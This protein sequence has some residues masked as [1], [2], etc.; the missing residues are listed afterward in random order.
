M[1]PRW[2]RTTR[3]ET[4]VVD[5]TA[6]LSLMVV[7]IPFLLITAVFSRMTILE[8]QAPSGKVGNSALSDPL[9]L[10][11][12]VREHTIEVHYRGQK[13]DTR[14]ART[15]DEQALVSLGEVVDE[16]KARFPQSLEATILLEPQISYEYLVH[17]MDVV[18]MQQ[19]WQDEALRKLERFPLIALGEIAPLP[20]RPDRGA[21]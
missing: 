7:L 8:L 6:F 21:R 18:R 20:R 5:V 14:I 3:R 15:P 2:Q 11:I 9:Q 19:Q 10:K 12:I 4:P 17:V 16:L 1:M 13:T